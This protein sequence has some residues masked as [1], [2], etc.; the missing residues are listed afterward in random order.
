MNHA[1]TDELGPR[2][3][4]ESVH[5]T[6]ALVYTWLGA[7]FLFVGV[8]V[9]FIPPEPRAPQHAMLIGG[10]AVAGFGA[11]CLIIGLVRLLP[12]RG[13][14]WH[15]HEH[16][17][18]L[19]RRSG[20]RVLLYKDVDVLT[21]KVVRVFFHG[22]CTGEVHDATFTTIQPAGKV[23]L[24]QVRRPSSTPGAG[25]D[26]PGELGQA[27]D[28]VAELIASRMT[29]Q[30]RRGEPIAWGK[31]IY[32]HPDGLALPSPAQDRISWGQIEHVAVEEG[33]FQLWRR[34]EPRPAIKVPTHLPN[35]LPGYR[36][37]L[38]R[39]DARTANAGT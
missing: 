32:I 18:R 25:L 26:R 8:L 7:A 28:K 34:G 15:V 35:F 16:G 39:L 23:R 4:G 37:I 19:V 22:V 9:S 27:C 29:A 1:R 30:L 13:A 31:S 20:E 2:L 6:P 3:Y 12:N 10:L 24:K 33:E 36:V 11:I 38:D 14:S 21:L 17:I 5:I